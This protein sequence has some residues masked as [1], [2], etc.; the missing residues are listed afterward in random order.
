M[1]EHSH[2]YH[3]EV[4]R[5]LTEVA[6]SKTLKPQQVIK[7]FS[8]GG[9]QHIYDFWRII[10]ERYGDKFNDVYRCPDCK[11]FEL[12]FET[13]QQLVSEALP[14]LKQMSLPTYH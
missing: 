2:K 12:E 13:Q 9:Q 7:D 10:H 5:A 11:K 6:K 4:L 14:S 1:S 8:S 3:K